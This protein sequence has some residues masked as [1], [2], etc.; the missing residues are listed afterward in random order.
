[1]RTNWA[2]PLALIV[3]LTG[4]ALEAGA[5]DASQPSHRSE[6]TAKDEPFK[7]EVK[8]QIIGEDAAKA[9]AFTEV[10]VDKAIADGQPIG[11]IG[12]FSRPIPNGKQ[13][14]IGRGGDVPR[15]F[16]VD[17]TAAAPA[18]RIVATLDFVDDPQPKKFDLLTGSVTVRLPA[19][20]SKWI[21][22]KS[23]DS[24]QINHALLRKQRTTA[25]LERINDNYFRLMFPTEP[26]HV[27]ARVVDAQGVELKATY[28]DGGL[29]GE[30]GMGWTFE[31]PIPAGS[32]LEFTL[33]ELPTVKIPFKVEN[34]Q[35]EE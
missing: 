9:L 25:R 16:R 31:K 18:D 11:R 3:G 24:Q 35:V 6:A 2:S 8:L 34:I 4:F 26:K 13:E 14:M 23:L 5:Q 22:I 30:F 27:F 1:M 20:D 15:V 12:R 29:N 10:I 17:R 28:G 19:A 33:E 21:R 32:V 7:C